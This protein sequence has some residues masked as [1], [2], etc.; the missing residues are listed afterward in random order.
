MT[1]TGTSTGTAPGTTTQTTSTPST[2]DTPLDSPGPAVTLVK[3][4]NASGGNTAPLVLG[5]TIQYS[6]LVTN[7]GNVPLRSVA[8]SDPTLGPVTCPA[9]GP[10]GLAPGGSVTCTATN[11]YTVGPADIAFGS[12]TDTATATG[13]SITGGGTP[14]SPPSTVIVQ[15]SSPCPH[16]HH[17]PDRHRRARRP[18]DRRS[19]G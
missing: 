19:A 1:V 3:S 7:S 18:P 8:V 4:A 14:T 16:G 10:S 15:A 13:V 9:L 17:Q 2:V 6:Y 11:I 5:E 12:V